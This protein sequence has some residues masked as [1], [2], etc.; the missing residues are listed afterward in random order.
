MK[1]SLLILVFFFSFLCQ[2]QAKKELEDQITDL[3]NSVSALTANNDKL[4]QD[5]NQLEQQLTKLQTTINE[6][7]SKYAEV[8][9][10]GLKQIK[11]VAELTQKMDSLLQGINTASSVPHES[12]KLINFTNANAKFTVPQGKTWAIHDAFV[13]HSND[14]NSYYILIKS[15]NGILMTDLSKNIYG[16]GLYYSNA[17]ANPTLPILLPE[18]TVF[19]LIV[20]TKYDNGQRALYDGQA[21]LNYIESE[22]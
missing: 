13:I 1:T 11:Q 9:E 4:K 18:N 3:N 17:L 5:K 12:A 15:L 6:C 22:N 20:Y 8:Q 2:G 19:E 21:F 7:Q 10:I 14:G 16:K